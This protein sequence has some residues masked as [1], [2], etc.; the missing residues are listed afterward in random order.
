MNPLHRKDVLKVLDQVRPYIKADG[1]DVELVDIADNGIVSVRLTGNCVGCASAGQTVFDGI[2][3]ALQGQLA[4]VTGVAQ[5]D[6]DYMPATSQSAATESV[7][8][9]HRRARRHLLDLLA[10]LDD[11]EPGKNLPEAVP[12]FINLARGELS[13]LL[14]LEEE[15]IYGAAESFLGRTA[16]PVAVLKKEHEQLHRL[17]TEFTDLVIR[18]GGAGGPGPGELRA[19]AQRMARYFEQHTQ[20][21]QSVLF[22]VLNEGLQ[23]DLQAELRED[24]VRHVQRL[25]LAGALAATK[26]KP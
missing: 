21:E 18:F 20:K 4:W 2:Q 22:N 23:P 17:F 11:L 19:A 26:E 14:R 3:S 16:G 6:A 12:A 13:Q 1:G 9:L 10:A 25:G 24:I 7:Q 5:V 8:A 15:V